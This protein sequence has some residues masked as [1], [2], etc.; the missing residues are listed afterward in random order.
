ML[1]ISDVER[2]CNKETLVLIKILNHHHNVY[3]CE[4]FVNCLAIYSFNC[5]VVGVGTV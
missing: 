3:I 1:I 5:G 4:P 2:I